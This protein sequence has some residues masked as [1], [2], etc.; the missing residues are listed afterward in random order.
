[1]DLLPKEYSKFFL[2][3][4]GL[5]SPF[6][7]LHS[8]SDAPVY[9]DNTIVGDWRCVESYRNREVTDCS[10]AFWR[11][12][13]DGVA[14]F[15]LPDK[16]SY[17]TYRQNEALDSLNI[18]ISSMRPVRSRIRWEGDTL[19]MTVVSHD[20]DLVRTKLL[21]ISY[22]YND[23]VDFQYTAIETMTDS[24][25]YV[26]NSIVI[27]AS[28]KNKT[29]YAFSNV[30]ITCRL[31]GDRS[32]GLAMANN[33]YAEYDFPIEIILPHSTIRRTIR[34]VPPEFPVLGIVY[35]IQR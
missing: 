32:E 34:L 31:L 2:L 19:V 21:K 8:C 12:D 16:T 9:S 25:M 33:L 24:A 13:S 14:S 6:I 7:L 11:F 3:I 26:G 28:V 17:G 30:T 23:S 1:M 4:V 10:A 15:I 27:H 35:L 22:L 18:D 5:I 20:E 29:D